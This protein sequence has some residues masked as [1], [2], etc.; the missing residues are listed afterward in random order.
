[1]TGQR[2]GARP[3][4]RTNA[5]LRNYG[6]EEDR[7]QPNRPLCEWWERGTIA[8]RPDRCSTDFLL[9]PIPIAEKPRKRRTDDI[10]SSLLSLVSFAGGMCAPVNGEACSQFLFSSA[11]V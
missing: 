2:R 1:M 3:R 6:R 9:G 5:T 8:E 11:L 4:T 7:H 10:G